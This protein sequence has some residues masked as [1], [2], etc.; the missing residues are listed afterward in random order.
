MSLAQVVGFGGCRDVEGVGLGVLNRRELLAEDRRVGV[1]WDAFDEFNGPLSR[2]L[3]L[4]AVIEV[5]PPL[6]E[7]EMNGGAMIGSKGFPELL[8]RCLTLFPR[9]AG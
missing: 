2:H 1:L 9:L 7:L 8:E 3:H 5:R 6:L 4:D